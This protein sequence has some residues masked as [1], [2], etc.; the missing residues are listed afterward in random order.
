VSE[1]QS[2]LFIRIDSVKQTDPSV[3]QT[4]TNVE[5]TNTNVEQTNI[6][7]EQTNTNIE[8]STLACENNISSKNAEI[9]ILS[10]NIELG[11]KFSENTELEENLDEDLEDEQTNVSNFDNYLQ[12]WLDILE[13]ERQRFEDEDTKEDMDENE[14]PVNDTHPAVDNNAKWELA[15][16]FK[17][18]EL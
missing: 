16:L 15:T 4:N 11:D 9:D 6:N 8:M 12:E 2:N 7:V 18:L 17:K 13:E 5:Q 10:E 1:Q 14:S 3:K